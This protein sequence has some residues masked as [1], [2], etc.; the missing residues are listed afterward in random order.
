MAL[1]DTLMTNFFVNVGDVVQAAPTAGDPDIAIVLGTRPSTIDSSRAFYLIDGD[2]YFGAL[3]TEVEALKLGGTDRFFYATSWYLGTADNPNNVPIG[4]GSFTSAWNA[5]AS[6][7]VGTMP[8]FE[9]QNGSG[10]PY[11]PFK[12][13]IAAMAAAG[14][15]VRLLVWCSPFLVNL[16]EAASQVPFYWGVNVHSLKSILELRALPG[17]DN[18][19]VMNTLAHTLGAMHLKMVVCG[20]STGFRAYASGMDFVQ[21]RNG[22]TVHD[23]AHYWH[24]IGIKVEGSGANGP[25]NLFMQLWNEQVQRSASTFK[26]YGQEIKSQVVGTPLVNHRSSVA[27]P[28]GKQHV[29]ILRTIPTMNFA[30]FGTDRAPVDC[31]KRLISGFKQRKISFAED[32]VFEFRAAQRKAVNAAQQ[33]IYIEDQAFENVELADWINARLKAVAGLKVILLF[34]GDPADPSSPALS[35]FMDHLV[36]GVATPEDRIVFGQASYTIHSK[37]TIIDDTWVSIGSSNC[38]RRSFYMDGE[39]SISVLDEEDP[40]LAKKLRKDLWGEHCEKVPGVACD[41]LLPLA[42]ALGV[43]RAGWGAAPGGFALSSRI[44]LKRIPFNYVAAPVPADSWEA[45]KPTLTE[46]RRDQI[47]GD[48]RLEY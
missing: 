7:A 28:G 2:Q 48:S 44:N 18:K 24:D 14:V 33:Y 34:M 21:N 16:Q 8:A 6:G 42:N 23:P 30:F 29:Q 10:G 38:M 20:D 25:Y 22:P 4:S 12:D 32:G 19:V 46:E 31:L 47:D 39:I 5:D 17:M 1:I 35:M 11:H 40:S 15:D 37:L 45:P 41:P 9:L 26:A 36:A 13:D 27:I 3:R 43:W